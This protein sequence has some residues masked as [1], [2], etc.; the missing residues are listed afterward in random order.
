MSDAMGFMLAA[1]RCEMQGLQGL[2]LTCA[3]VER[4]S[5]L[6][7][8]LQRERGFSNIYLGSAGER[9]LPGLE[10]LVEDSMVE[11]RQV[12]EGLRR[13]DLESGC[14]SDKARLFNRIAF[15]L[16][17]LDGLPELREKVRSRALS[18]KDATRAFTRP[19]GGLL[20]VVFEA[21]DTAVDPDITRE[22]VALFNFMQGKE[23]AGQERALGVAGF[24][25]GHFEPS[26]QERLRSLQESQQRCFTTVEEYAEPAILTLWAQ[27]CAHASCAEIGRLR[28]VA[29]RS[30]CADPITAPLGEIWFELTSWRIDAMK[31]IEERMTEQLHERCSAK[32][33]EA[34]AALD[35][36]HAQAQRLSSLGETVEQAPAQVFNIQATDL[37]AAPADNLGNQM[38]RSMLDL[39]HAQTRRLQ[40]LSEE[41]EEAR[42]SLSERKVIERAKAALMRQHGLQDDEAYRL[43]QNAAMERGQRLVDVAQTVL[44]Y[45]DLL[46]QKKRPARR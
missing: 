14:G 41:L 46:Q 7:H 5:R 19:I 6:V 29:A 24:A 16:H 27:L 20:A 39:L 31:Q 45:A 3:L 10:K 22:L 43:L 30:S 12:R 23:L 42:R 38:Q 1:R 36:H 25:A 26:Q 40:A 18:P 28:Q 2:E 9:F 4:I 21:A 34:Q 37:D 35:D 11:A 44:T 33:A 32:I 13:I 17:S 15:V 8:A